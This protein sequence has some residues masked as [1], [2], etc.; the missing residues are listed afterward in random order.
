V[1]ILLIN[2]EYPPIGAG[3]ATASQ[4]IARSLVASGHHSTI[5]TAGIGDLVGTSEEDGVRVIRLASRRQR[6]ES[7]PISE[8]VSFMLW[9]LAAV[10]RVVR[11]ERID[12]I[13][14]FFSFPSGPSAWWA[15]RDAGVPYVISLRGGDVPGAEPRLALIHRCLA[16]LRRPILRSAQA[17]VANSPGLKALAEKGYPA[18]VHMVP[19]GVD[20]IFFSPPA[21]P[22]PANAPA[23]LLFVGRFQGQKNLFWL[24]EQLAVFRRL[25]ALPFTLDLVGDGPLRDALTARIAQLQLADIVRFHGWKDRA[26]LRAHYRCADLLINPSLY[27]GMP[28]V[29]L[30][31][32]ACGCPV[33][34]SRVPGNDT[35]VVD[36]ASGW[37]YSL[38]D[39]ADFS[40]CL[41][42]LLTRPD[43]ATALSVAARIRVEGEY[44]WDRTTQSYLELLGS[45]L[46][47][48][49]DP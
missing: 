7:A 47:Q 40:D 45:P 49:Q 26:D 15:H 21:P 23:R 3:A 16:P 43:I 19:N 6:R 13:I 33:L 14:A 29:V 12:G 18:Q 25:T 2:Y 36:R 46:S 20:T 17:V 41:R 48:S 22:R 24:V 37:L 8:M 10:R 35:V 34:A 44:S 42:T 28:N 31:A 11:S 30:E 27:E 4:A 1:R 38:G 39:A 32:M 5:L 9:S